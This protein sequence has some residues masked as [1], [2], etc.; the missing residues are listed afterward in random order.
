MGANRPRLVPLALDPTV[1]PCRSIPPS[2]D[3]VPFADNDI[4]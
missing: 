3:P 4:V 2:I 1:V